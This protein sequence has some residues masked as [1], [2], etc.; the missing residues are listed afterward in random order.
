MSRCLYYITKNN[1]DSFNIRLFT[2]TI[3]NTIPYYQGRKAYYK[4]DW[5]VTKDCMEMVTK[6]KEI[7]IDK[8]FFDRLDDELI[9]EAQTMIIETLGITYK[10]VKRAYNMSHNNIPLKKESR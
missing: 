7:P 4:Q 5:L 10:N 2:A 9:A 1:D 8:T 3:D 6:R